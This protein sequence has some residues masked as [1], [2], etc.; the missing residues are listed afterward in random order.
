MGKPTI[1]WFRQDL[2]LEDQPALHAAIL[3]GD[4]IIPLF[5]WAP[6]EEG[7]WAPGGASRWWL[8][9]SLSSL[10]KELYDLG[11]TLILRQDSSLEAILSIIKQ[12]GADAVFWNRRYEPHLIERDLWIEHEL[13]RR[14]IDVQIYNGLLLFNPWKILNKQNKP[15]QVFT[16]FWK[17]CCREA[18]PQKPFRKPSAIIPNKG[19][20]DSEKLE[21]FQLLPKIPWDE[22]L[23]EKW[24]PGEPSGKQLLKVAL[25]H[26]VGHYDQD[27]NELAKKGT[28]ELSPYLHHG[29]ISPRRI[30]WA[31]RQ[32]FASQ[33][34]AEAFLRQLGWREFAY[35][36]LYHFPHTPQEALHSK[37]AS[38]QWHS[39]EQ[40]LSAWQN[41][42][43]GY[44]IVD[45]GMRQLWRT[46]WMHNRVRLIVG[47]FLVKDLLIDWQEG[48]R[49]FWDTLVDADL[50]NNTLGWQWVAGCGADAAPYFRI[51][52][53]V[54]QGRKFDKTGEYVRRW[55]PEIRALPDAWIH[56]PWEA[57]AEILHQAGIEL[58]K[59]YP[60]PIVD[61]DQARKE[62]LKHV[63]KV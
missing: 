11:S 10:Q 56:C 36:L 43:T 5:I 47:S 27:R 17:F 44:P 46:G 58:G 7:E 33:E 57:P 34:G 52:N 48:A 21:Q 55:V 4:P 24:Q 32:Q 53:P 25:Q 42:L 41:G 51:F 38:I 45:A 19:H 37:F 63:R 12:S 35:Y 20:I 50:A 14:C 62:A 15:Y 31:I 6:A 61:H 39:N 40:A 28:S 26:I 1:V 18:E 54:S 49:W 16:S 3:K 30:W 13:R 9:G 59:S 29:E 22:G 60:K 2:R 8:N 23:R